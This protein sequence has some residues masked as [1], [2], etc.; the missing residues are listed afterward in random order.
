MSKSSKNDL[1]IFMIAVG[2]GVFLLLPLLMYSHFYVDWEN[3][4]WIIR[5]YAEYFSIHHRFP[6]IINTFDCVGICY[7]QY[8]GYLFY[9]MMGLVTWVTGN[10]K[11]TYF[12][13]SLTLYIIIFILFFLVFQKV[14]SRRQ[15]DMYLK[16]KTASILICVTILCN[17]YIHTNLYSRNAMTEYYAVLFL[18]VTIGAYV[19]SVLTTDVGH[20]IL[21]WTVSALGIVLAIGSHPIT[22]EIGGVLFGLIILVTFPTV[23]RKCKSRPKIVPVIIMDIILVV[24]AV[25]PWVYITLSNIAYL[26]VAQGTITLGLEGKPFEDSSYLVRLLTFPSDKRT[27]ARGLE[28][29]TPNLDMQINMP[30]VFVFCGSLICVMRNRSVQRKSKVAA[31][32]VMIVF[33]VMLIATSSQFFRNYTLF[34]F[35]NIQ[36]IYRL[37]TYVDLIAILGLI[38]NLWLIY[39]YMHQAISKKVFTIGLIV[40]ATL[41]VH[42]NLITWEHA[43]ASADQVIVDETDTVYH[44]PFTFYGLNGYVSRHIKG[45]EWEEQERETHIRFEVDTNDGSVV[46]MNEVE[47][48]TQSVYTNIQAAE[49]NK[50][51]VDGIRVD[52]KLL[53]RTSSGKLAFYCYEEE[54]HSVEYRLELPKMYVVLRRLSYVAILVL[55]AILSFMWVKFAGNPKERLVVN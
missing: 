17:T 11:A 23:I 12:I 25:S 50:I 54:P 38:Y 42:N 44:L 14:L 53:F 41:A 16:T 49:Y 26:D 20:S 15:E 8:Y 22:A 43:K 1:R 32:G 37:I 4:Y 36:F 2:I 40:C 9:Q 27:L 5:Y 24:L 31:M 29:S 28:T 45:W 47:F 30:I 46:P 6:L 10:V 21:L 18:Y 55:I 39:S 52:D 34:V 3:H 48:P 51:Y 7:P 35:R 33:L 19:L 13:V